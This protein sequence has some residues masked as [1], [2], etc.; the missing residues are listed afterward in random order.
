M[1]QLPIRMQSD[2]RIGWVCILQE[3]YSVAVHVLNQD[4]RTDEKAGFMKSEGDPNTY[5][6]GRT[7]PHYVAINRPQFGRSGQLL[8]SQIVNEMK[9]TFPGI[10]Y[11]L[12][13]GIGGGAPSQKADIRLGDVV[14]GMS[15]LP[16]KKGKE[17]DNTFKITGKAKEPHLSFLMLLQN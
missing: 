5:R 2:F 8:A 11:W 12:L 14:L 1:E 6:L 9:S 17:K 4:Y 7:G 10:R 16:Y 15:V 13:V 3:E